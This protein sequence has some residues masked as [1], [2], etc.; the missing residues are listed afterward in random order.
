MTDVR[1]DGESL[2][3]EEVAAVAREGARVALTDE[4]RTKIRAS[5]ERIE[6]I[7]EH[8]EAVY[9]VNTGFGDLVSERI[10]KEDLET[11]QENLIRSHASGTGSE[12]DREVVRAMMLARA[13]TLAKGYSGIREP[14]VEALVTMLNEGV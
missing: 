1:I 2:T 3:P 7:L 11:L 13:N 9:G 14:V 12:L 8:D 6:D 5:R 4:A 10:P